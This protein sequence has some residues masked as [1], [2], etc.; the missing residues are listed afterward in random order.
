MACLV[1]EAQLKYDNGRDDDNDVQEDEGVLCCQGALVLLQ[2]KLA[3]WLWCVLA[4][5]VF[6]ACVCVRSMD[7]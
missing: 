4:G 6:T 1:S 3:N 2:E 5:G 7:F